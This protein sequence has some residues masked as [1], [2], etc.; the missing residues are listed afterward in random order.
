MRCLHIPLL[1]Q[2]IYWKYWRSGYFYVI[3]YNVY[4]YIYCLSVFSIDLQNSKF[5]IILEVCIEHIYCIMYMAIAY[6]YNLDGFCNSNEIITRC[7]KTWIYILKLSAIVKMHKIRKYENTNI[8][9]HCFFFVLFSSHDVVLLM[10]F[11]E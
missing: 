11:S 6:S 10:T 7:R 4:V 3:L 5:T 9:N 2:S 8:E 1:H